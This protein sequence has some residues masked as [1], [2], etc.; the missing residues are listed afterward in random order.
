M[1]AP[2]HPGARKVLWTVAGWGA[3]L[4]VWVV[5]ADRNNPLL[6]AGPTDTLDAL[7]EVAGNGTLLDALATTLG[8]LLG[9]VGIGTAIGVVAGVAAGA[10][11]PLGAPAVN[12]YAAGAPSAGKFTMTCWPG[13]RSTIRR[14]G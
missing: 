13:F 11:A 2:R 10:V 5:A 8:R 1:R 7:G 6:V 3:L 12:G 14:P 9:G 4:V